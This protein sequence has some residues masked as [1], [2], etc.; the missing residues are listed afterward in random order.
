MGVNEWSAGRHPGVFRVPLVVLARSPGES[1]YLR[2]RD[3]AKPRRLFDR[4]VIAQLNSMLAQVVTGGTGRRSQLDFTYSAGKTGT[5]SS[6]R[7]AWF[8]GFTGKYVA[9][10][11][12]GNDS[13]RPTNR[14]TGGSL[15]AQ[16]WKNFMTI[17]HDSMDIPQ[18]VGLP[19]HPAQVEER[20]RLAAIRAAN[21]TRT[22]AKNQRRD[23]LPN[24]TRQI[25]ERLARD[26]SA[27]SRKNPDA[28]S[29]GDR[30]N[31]TN[32]TRKTPG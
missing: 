12:F 25:L 28:I 20:A 9:G 6:Y 32:G 1:V 23:E 27:I 5:S 30:A 16:A 19:L 3:E 31:I 11:W 13:Y 8:M 24:R 14:V 7:D 22:E 2:E 18:I 26:L 29:P 17:A 4:N 10:V 21:P 15:P